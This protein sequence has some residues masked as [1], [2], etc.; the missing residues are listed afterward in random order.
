MSATPYLVLLTFAF[1]GGCFNPD[2][3]NAVFK[4]DAEHACPSGLTC[5]SNLC[6]SLSDASAQDAGS[7]DPGDGGS[8]MSGCADK[9]G[10][11]V[12]ASAY[13]CPGSFGQGQAESK[14]AAGWAPCTAGQMVDLSLCNNLNG[15]FVARVPAYYLNPNRSSPSCGTTMGIANPVWYG[16]GDKPGTRAYV[17][18][19]DAFKCSGFAK[20][21]DC[22]SRTTATWECPLSFDL[23]KTINKEPA[24]GVLCCR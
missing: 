22:P 3:S 16:C 2:T 4:C 20:S 12:G 7:Q 14:C 18:V 10:F 15:F 17:A 19:H 5:L 8:S 6:V 23:Q 1:V 21:L 24:D 11:P 13:A 9:S